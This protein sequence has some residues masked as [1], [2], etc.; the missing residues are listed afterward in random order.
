MTYVSSVN[1]SIFSF[2]SLTRNHRLGCR[3]TRSSTF[4]KD[5]ICRETFSVVLL[6]RRFLEYRPRRILSRRSLQQTLSASSDAMVTKSWMLIHF[7]PAVRRHP[8]TSVS[9]PVPSGV[10]TTSCHPFVSKRC[11]RSLRQRLTSKVKA[12]ILLCPKILIYCQ[13]SEKVIAFLLG[14]FAFYHATL[15]KEFSGAPLCT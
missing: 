2:N 9:L 3:R 13:H 10:V 4:G 5:S 6:T 12:L 14:H 11:H 8:F 1:G 15:V 7:I